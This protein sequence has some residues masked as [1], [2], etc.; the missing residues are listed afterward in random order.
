[1]RTGAGC[2]TA[3]FAL[4]SIRVSK[5]PGDGLSDPDYPGQEIL[6]YPVPVRDRLTI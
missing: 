1:M 6:A 3:P 5:S 4:D 2:A